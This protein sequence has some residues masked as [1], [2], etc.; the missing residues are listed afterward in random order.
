MR[1][2]WVTPLVAR[3]AIGRVSITVT[4]A[5]AQTGDDVTLIG[6]EAEPPS[7]PL[8]A[9]SLKML[10]WS[11]LAAGELE[12]F[13][14]VVV[15]LGDNYLFHGGVFP[16]LEQAPCLGVFHDFYLHN[17]FNG[18]LAARGLGGAAA[19]VEMV[20][21]YGESCRELAQRAAA[22]QLHLTELADHF[23][24]T[25]WVASRCA[26]AMAHAEFY[27]NRLASSCPGPVTF[28]R[29]PFGG[30]SAPELPRR[31]RK[32]LKVL[33]VGV[34]NPNKCADK[35]IEGIAASPQ[36][37]DTVEY[38][39][40]G[41]IEPAERSRLEGLAVQLGYDRLRIVG[42]VDD[43]ELARELDEADIICCL[44]NPVLEG[45]SASAIEGMLSGRP[46]IVADAGFYAELPD[47][48]VFKSPADI[49]SKALTSL[50][51]R[52]ANDE[53]LRRAAGSRARA[54]AEQAFSLPGYCAAVREAMDMTTRASPWLAVGR[55]L[56]EDIASLHLQADDPVIARIGGLLDGLLE[57][58]G[59]SV[60][61]PGARR[62]K[63]RA[64]TPR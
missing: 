54:W 60:A 6:C 34:M 24:M 13:D 7:E 50:L 44:R 61:A 5:L 30:R 2:A 31:R 23:P 63:R 3:S 40:V 9:S 62:P 8:H 55:A 49:P 58:P 4:E 52:L 17:L 21:T 56:G 57:S 36:L 15:N 53:P 47:D 16:L 59:P 29:M 20:A 45:S 18:W 10:H 51:L 39:L 48:M 64:A 38:R 1:I 28:G 32:R 12:T 42:P 27:L 46:V 19:E 41:P 11:E 22:G 35:L 43:Q 37:S 14:S 33:T 26:G 25:E